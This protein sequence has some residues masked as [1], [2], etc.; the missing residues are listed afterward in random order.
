MAS[1][2]CTLFESHYHHGVAALTNSLYKN[3]YRGA[4]YAGYRGSLPAWASSSRADGSVHWPGATRLKVADGLDLHFLPLETDYHLTNYKPDFMLRLWD[5][6]ARDAGGMYYF[7]PD[8]VVTA[9]WHFFEEWISC[10][11]ALCEDVNSPLAQHHPRRVA[12][13]R[14]FGKNDIKLDFKSPIYVNG[15][16]TGL[17]RENCSFLKTWKQIQEVMA[18]QIGGLNRSSLTGTPLPA[19]SS[20]PFAPFGKTDQDALNAAVEAWEGSL[21]FAGQDG[22]A[23]KY[24]TSLMPHALG[25]PKPWKKN[26]ILSALDGRPATLADKAY[27]LNLDGPIRNYSPMQIKIRRFT[28]LFAGLINRFYRRS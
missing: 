8:I 1:T 26:F 23:F 22:M 15:G 24:G 16:F 5:G 3:G 20:G 19:G 10:G 12:W 17:S 4:I 27:W 13:R 9:P 7:D 6:P 11:V 28:I 18:P 14:Y 21:S 25:Q 2:I